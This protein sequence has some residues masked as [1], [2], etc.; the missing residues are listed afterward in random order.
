MVLQ[1]QQAE[2]GL[3]PGD[4]QING[5]GFMDFLRGAKSFARKSVGRIFPWLG[6]FA[7]KQVAPFAKKH[8]LPVAKDFGRQA[9]SEGLSIVRD[10]AE[11]GLKGKKYDSTGA[12]KK[13]GKRLAKNA[14]R[15]VE[16]SVQ[17]SLAYPAEENDGPDWDD[18]KSRLPGAVRD[19]RV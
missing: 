2:F 1:I 10:S 6:N 9:L 4:N 8:L 19:A 5:E 14:V 15:G 3:R 12:A 11:A 18:I 7:R 17:G 13:A 16:G